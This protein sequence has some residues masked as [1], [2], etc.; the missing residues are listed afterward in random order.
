M[1]ASTLTSAMRVGVNTF[2]FGVTGS[3]ASTPSASGLLD[4]AYSQQPTQVLHLLC[5]PRFPLPTRGGSR[6]QHSSLME[7]A[8]VPPPLRS[9]VTGQMILRPPSR[10]SIFPDGLEIPCSSK[11]PFSF[12]ISLY[13]YVYLS[14]RS[15]GF[16]YFVIYICS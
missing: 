2:L 13:F 5:R 10:L 15:P 4:P 9:M 14:A 6:P 12:A 3:G 16:V 8:C 11:A 1:Q 7:E